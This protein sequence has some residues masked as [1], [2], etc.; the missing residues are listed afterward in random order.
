MN[1]LLF[2]SAVDNGYEDFI[3]LYVYFANKYN[4]NSKFEFL[5]KNLTNDFKELINNFNKQFNTDILLRN[6]TNNINANRL[7]FLEEPITKCTYTYIGDIDIFINENILPFHINQMKE[8]NTIY[9]NCLRYPSNTNR[10]SGLHF[11]KSDEYFKQTE[12]IRNKYIKLLIDKKIT[13][14]DEILLNNIILSL[15]TCIITPKDNI[16][17][18]IKRPIHGIHISLNRKPFTSTLEFP[19]E[20]FKQ[21]FIYDFYKS[22]DYTLINKFLSTKLQNILK[23]CET[24]SMFN[25]N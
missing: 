16:D 8:F 3:P 10:M 19:K 2:F 18:L 14:G 1:N 17:F 7:R 12:S 4:P 22:D 6:Y 21:M 9:S 5:V 23:T 20:L 11:V 15:N 13:T 24:Y 25:N